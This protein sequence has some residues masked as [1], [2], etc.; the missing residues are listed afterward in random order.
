MNIFTFLKGHGNE[1]CNLIGS[2]R[3]PYFP[4]S[5]H[6]KRQRSHKSLSTSLL[7]LPFF[8]NLYGFSG[9]AVFLRCRS[10]PQADK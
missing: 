6:G 9:W 5:A 10:L 2:L 1:S 4:I 8:I 7:S 3:G